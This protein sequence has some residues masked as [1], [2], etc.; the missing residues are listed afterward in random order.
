MRKLLRP[1]DKALFALAFGG[2]LVID[3]YIRGYVSYRRR[4]LG[5]L[6]GKPKEGLEKCVRRA[7]NADYIEKVVGKNGPCLRI[8][9]NGRLRLNRDFPLFKFQDRKWDGYWTLVSYDIPEKEKVKRNYL[10]E[11]LRTIGFGKWQRS[12]YISPHDFGQDIREWIASKDL[13]QWVNVSQSNNLAEDEKK[14][15]WE[16]FDLETLSGRYNFLLDS[17]RKIDL[18]GLSRRGEAIDHFF[19]ILMEDPFLPED[20]LPPHWPAFAIRKA[21]FDKHSYGW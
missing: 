18:T 9:G 19:E 3:A 11:K 15:A 2:D 20:L 4:D 5:L 1:S 16:V 21:L 6:F 8:T 12:V 14:L 7:V 17:F 13:S 10:R